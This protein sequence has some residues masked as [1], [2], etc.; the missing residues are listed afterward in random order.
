M[1]LIPEIAQKLGVEIGELPLIL[2][3]AFIVVTFLQIY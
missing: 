3:M 2:R 1:N